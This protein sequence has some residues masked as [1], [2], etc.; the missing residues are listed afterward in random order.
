MTAALVLFA[1]TVA[2]AAGGLIVIAALCLIRGWQDH[3][4]HTGHGHDS[5]VSY[6]FT[7]HEDWPCPHQQE[8]WNG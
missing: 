8:E 7:C 3:A 6:C 1:A 5:G 2:L 4:A